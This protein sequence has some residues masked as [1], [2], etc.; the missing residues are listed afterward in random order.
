MKQKKII[1]AIVILHIVM[2]AIYVLYSITTVLPDNPTEGREQL[3]LVVSRQESANT[4]VLQ[5]FVRE[6]GAWR[7]NFSSPVVIG[8]NGMAWGR[9]LHNEKARLL[10]EPV[11]TEGDGRSPKG[12]FELIRAYGYQE[13]VQ[14][15]FPYKEITPEMVC[16]DDSR[17]E[18]YTMIV[19]EESIAGNEDISH[20]NM[21]QENDPYRYA[22][23]VGHNTASPVKDAGSC[24]FLHVWRGED[25]P[26]A[27]CTAMSE[28][29]M[30]RL[31][32]WLDPAKNPCLVQLTRISYL[33]L[34]E[35][36]RLPDITI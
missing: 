24:I 33:R 16:I 36:W 34:K 26:T 12:A 19:S 11:K 21:I 10:D 6:N 7:F 9:G 28:A 35:E 4:A 15:K 3:V 1:F 20:E 13:D 30:M 31:I 29:N 25:S 27:G 32:T 17:S 2:G 14:I 5:A 22:I 8:R 23:L 18:Y